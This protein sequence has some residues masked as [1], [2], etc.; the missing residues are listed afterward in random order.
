MLVFDNFE[1]F[2]K[3]LR[4]WQNITGQK[5]SLKYFSSPVAVLKGKVNVK[6]YTTRKELPAPTHDCLYRIL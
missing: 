3:A 2:K 5:T 1:S 6:E 4:A